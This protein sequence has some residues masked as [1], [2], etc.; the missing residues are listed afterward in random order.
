MS[1]QKSRPVNIGQIKQ[2]LR[3][4]KKK[5]KLYLSHC[6]HCSIC[7]ESCFLYMAKDKDPQYMPSYKVLNSV[8]KLYKKR[9]SVDRRFLDKIKKIVWRNCVLC[10]RCYCPVGVDVPSMIT[11][12]RSICRSQG[13]FPEL[14]KS[15]AGES[16][17]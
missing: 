14:D 17:L 9:G 12:A 4:R 13:V 3:S 6:V 16:W 5:M 11:F 10:R 8:G 15:E 1:A 2:M 7:A